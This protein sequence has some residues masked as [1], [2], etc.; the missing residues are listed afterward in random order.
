M[1]KKNSEV[2]IK[3]TQ[4]IG[5]RYDKVNYQL[6]KIRSKKSHALLQSSSPRPAL[7][8]R[9]VG[10][11]VSLSFLHKIEDV[12]LSAQIWR[13]HEDVIQICISYIY[14]YSIYIYIYIFSYIYI[15]TYTCIYIYIY[16]YVYYKAYMI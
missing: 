10:A 13:C 7:S 15:Y 1:V 5:A 11:R 2:V 4:I 16:T 6:K 12:L 8:R 9:S 14:I 3:F